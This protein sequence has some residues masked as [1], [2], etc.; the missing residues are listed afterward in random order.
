VGETDKAEEK[1]EDGC[2][3]RILLPGYYCRRSV[4]VTDVMNGTKDWGEKWALV[5]EKANKQTCGVSK[6]QQPTTTSLVLFVI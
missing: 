4:F 2:V 6:H 5:R 3:S 1:G